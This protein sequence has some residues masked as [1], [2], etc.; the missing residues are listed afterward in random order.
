MARKSNNQPTEAE[1]EILQILWKNNPATV[2]EVHEQILNQKEVGYTTTL[3]IM[4]NM[5]SKG[6]LNRILEGKS[7]LYTPA[8][9][10]SKT[11]TALLDR[12]LDNAFGGSASSL[13][14]QL[15]G[16]GK[17]TRKELKEIKDIIKK[18]EGQSYDN[19]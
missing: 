6:F 10:E 5:V 8:I 11:K 2:K 18:M 17:T 1:L 16:N 19:R 3:K 7:H 4:Q 9:E 12:F 14:L 15:L 13:M